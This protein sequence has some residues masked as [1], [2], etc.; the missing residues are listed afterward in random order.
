MN[1]PA[2]QGAN[3]LTVEEAVQATVQADQIARAQATEAARVAQFTPTPTPLSQ[4][5]FEKE[6]E[7]SLARATAVASL[8]QHAVFA[9]LADPDCT[10]DRLEWV[11]LSPDG[12]LAASTR[13]SQCD[14][15]NQIFV[16]DTVTGEIVMHFN[17]LWPYEGFP[18]DPIA[19]S[20]DGLTA[21][22][23]V[24]QD[25]D[26]STAEVYRTSD[27]TKVAEL[28]AKPQLGAHNIFFTPDGKRVL[29]DHA[30]GVSVYDAGTWEKVCELP[31]A[32]A[33][34][35]PR[36]LSANMDVVVGGEGSDKGVDVAKLSNCTVAHDFPL[37][38]FEYPIAVNSDGTRLYSQ[39]NAGDSKSVIERDAASGEVLS[40]R[41]LV[42]NHCVQCRVQMVR[43]PN[44]EWTTLWQRGERGSGDASLQWRDD[45]SARVLEHPM[46]GWV[47]VL[48]CHP[49]GAFLLAAKVYEDS[50]DSQVTP[51]MAFEIVSGKQIGEF[52]L[53][54]LDPLKS[55]QRRFAFSGNGNVLALPGLRE[56]GNLQFW[57][58]DEWLA[59]LE[60]EQ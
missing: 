37:E 39:K 40:E 43:C 32:S 44:S 6:V 7:K 45:G 29:I 16:H 18:D 9:K 27:W 34:G 51:I 28:G 1:A 52:F 4:E 8:A 23:L 2:P 47:Q 12:A 3:T 41:E 21:V 19:F 33:V 58:L 48:K 60:S 14:R 42:P 10:A 26:G 56:Q 59:T 46:L 20:P 35:R 49:S 17:D 53:P 54:P 55:H 30:K 57:H 36:L 15:E 24:P 22:A 11:I 5:D 38:R 31:V 50:N 13:S 25:D